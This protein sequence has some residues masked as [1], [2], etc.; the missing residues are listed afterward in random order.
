MERE[1]GKEESKKER[2][3]SSRPLLLLALS[4][5]VAL[6]WLQEISADA[7][8]ALLLWNAAVEEFVP[9]VSPPLALVPSF[10]SSLISP[11][12]SLSVVF[13]A[14]PGRLFAQ[15]LPHSPFKGRA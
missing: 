5:H 2:L 6:E 8:G 3:S 15:T 7:S 14:C 12:L 9:K 11:F 1:E 4:Y 10:V 13:G